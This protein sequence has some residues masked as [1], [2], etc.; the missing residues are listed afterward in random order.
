MVE[1]YLK[2]IWKAQEW[3]GRSVSTN[4]ISSVLGV[5]PSSV[6]A[7]LKKLARD[8]FIDYQPYGSIELTPAGREV[9]VGV[10]RRHRLLETYLVE[11]LGLGWDEVHPEADALEHAVSDLVLARMDEVL[12]YPDR[13]PHGDSI[14]RA[15]G[16]VVPNLASRLSE[17]LPGDGGRVVRISD[18]EP[19]I[20]RY[21]EARQIRVGTQ[22]RVVA[23]DPE[24]GS[25]SIV[26]GDEG[27]K[28]AEAVEI[29]LG[30]A[31]AMFVSVAPR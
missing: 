9:A 19:A 13:D 17:L 10:V 29:A 28:P 1:D 5:T 16:S 31:G 8:G 27:G 3:P 30:A 2:I 7:N 12:G 23:T 14:P 18:Q 6:S 11:R 4:E 21:L 24:A 22:L 15:D 20:L 25:V 26:R